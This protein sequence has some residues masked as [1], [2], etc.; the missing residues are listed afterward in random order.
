MTKMFPD[1]GVNAADAKN[2]LPDSAVNATCPELWYSTSRCAPRFDPAAA[3]AMLAEDI[4]L[5][6][7]GEVVYDC[8]RLD[9]IERAV[10]YIDQRGLTTGTVFNGGPFDYVAVMDPILTRYNDHLTLII[11]PAMTNQ[12]AVRVNIDGRG[13]V[14]VLRNDGQQM[15]SADLKAW[16]P[17]CI[18]Y[19]GGNFYHVGLCPSQVPLV[20]TGTIDAWIRTDGNDATGDGTANDPTKAFRTIQG[21]WNTVGSRYAASALFTIHMRLG[22]PGNYEFASL[23][24]YGGNVMLSGDAAN[25]QGYRIISGV[26]GTSCY[27]LLLRDMNIYITGV[28]FVMSN[29]NMN[30]NGN[31]CLRMAGGE[32]YIDSCYATL[33]ATAPI[34]HVFYIEGGGN[35]GSRNA[36]TVEGNGNTCGGGVYIVGGGF[37]GNAPGLPVS[38]WDWRGI[39]FTAASHF[40]SNGGVISMSNMG[41]VETGVVTGKEYDATTNSILY[42]MGHTL[43]GNAPGTF[44]T[45]AQIIP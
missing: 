7:K 40:V 15:R 1:S 43:P 27:A 38:N 28:N 14:P 33:D 8:D 3:N 29:G 11:V 23:G 35:F 21:A 13:L 10:R 19:W 34:A 25:P 18:S 39:N 5:V 22:I 24:P 6:M 9:N 32:T 12:A 2:S 16:I 41:I 17:A 45:G 31:M 20:A 37:H 36:I 44:A 42:L 4:N 30:A 26:S